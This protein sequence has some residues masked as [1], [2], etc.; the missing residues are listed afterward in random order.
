MRK[1]GLTVYSPIASWYHLSRIYDMGTTASEWETENRN[2][3]KGASLIRL[4]DMPGLEESVGTNMERAWA[5]EFDI[6][7]Q[8]YDPRGLGV[9]KYFEK[10]LC[11]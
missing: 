8:L 11:A 2:M 10:T 6:R 3:L 4:I 1:M 9:Y 7:E 5:K